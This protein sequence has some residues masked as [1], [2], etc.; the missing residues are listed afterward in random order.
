MSNKDKYRNSPISTID[1]MK[2]NAVF[3]NA[4]LGEDASK[5]GAGEAMNKLISTRTNILINE[6]FGR[7]N[8]SPIKPSI[9]KLEKLMEK[10]H[11]QAKEDIEK[12][13]SRYISDANIIRLADGMPPIEI[14]RSNGKAEIT[15]NGKKPFA[16]RFGFGKY[17]KSSPP[18][19]NK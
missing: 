4:A 19:H 13:F 9:G 6:I 10:A 5:I 8:V 7:A 14:E 1:I 18:L 11:S 15:E 2:K 17:G 3:V 12:N 16:E